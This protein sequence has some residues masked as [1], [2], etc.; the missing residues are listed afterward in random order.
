MS[1]TYYFFQ[2]CLDHI[3]MRVIHITNVN[4]ILSLIVF[5][6]R[7]PST[8]RNKDLCLLALLC[9]NQIVSDDKKATLSFSQLKVA[10][11]PEMKG[12][13][14]PFMKGIVMP[15]ISGTDVARRCL[16]YI[17]SNGPVWKPEKSIKL[18]YST[19]LLIGFTGSFFKCLKETLKEKL[20]AFRNTACGIDEGKKILL[21][22]LRFGVDTV[23]LTIDLQ[24]NDLFKFQYTATFDLNSFKTPHLLLCCNRHRYGLS[25]H[26][27]SSLNIGL[28]F[29]QLSTTGLRHLKAISHCH[30]PPGNAS[31]N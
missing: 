27:L 1:L 25:L 16:E 31:L 20:Y 26:F 6:N 21:F 5:L 29:S 7:N 19:F 30:S 4:V 2:I 12:I 9:A 15:F 8:S 17:C 24:S 22:F 28:G 18:N 3:S 23:L 13:V 11:C 10:R 14:M